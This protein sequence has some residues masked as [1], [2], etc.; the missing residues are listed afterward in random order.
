MSDLVTFHR[1]T[2]YCA[3]HDDGI[4]DAMRHLGPRGCRDE[5]HVSRLSNSAILRTDYET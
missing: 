4:L 3:K 2:V 1:T 5:R